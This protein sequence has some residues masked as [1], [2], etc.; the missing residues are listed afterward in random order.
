[1]VGAN[2]AR[3]INRLRLSFHIAVT[4]SL[5]GGALQTHC[6]EGIKIFNDSLPHRPSDWIGPSPGDSTCVLSAE[7]LMHLDHVERGAGD[8]KPTARRLLQALTLLSFLAQKSR[9]NHEALLVIVRLHLLLGT[10]SLALQ[11]YCRLAI[12]HVQNDTLAY[13]MFTR[14]S[15]SLPWA[16]RNAPVGDQDDRDDLDPTSCLERALRLYEKSKTQILRTTRTAVEEGAYHQIFGFSEFAKKLDSSVCKF[17]FEVE[18]QRIRR[19]RRSNRSTSK[20]SSVTSINQ[21][22]PM[23]EL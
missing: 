6:L 22:K 18:L 14:I 5:E 3:R 11:T 10:G 17:M 13:N 12:K 9:N 23:R 7:A 8:E 2:E 19:H 15:S 16:V 20:S 1:M 21:G 4:K